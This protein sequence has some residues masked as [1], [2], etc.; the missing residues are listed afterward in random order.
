MMAVS[1]LLMMCV[2]YHITPAYWHR[3]LLSASGQSSMCCQLVDS[4]VC[5]LYEAW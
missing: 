5:K 4:Q 2:K 3:L 1:R